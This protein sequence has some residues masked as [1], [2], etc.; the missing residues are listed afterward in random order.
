MFNEVPFLDRFE[1]AAL[2]GFRAVEFMFPWAYEP[3]RIA[4][5]ATRHGLEIVLFNVGGGDWDGGERGIGSVPGREDELRADVDR[6]RHYANI[7]GCRKLHLMAGK[8]NG[9]RAA[10][11]AVLVEN[12][13][14][15]ATVVAPDGIDILIEPINT[16]VDIPGYFYATTADA[17][18]VI[19]EVGLPNVKLQYDIY[20]MQIMEGDVARTIERLLPRIGHIQLADNPGRHE[21]GTGE[22]AYPWLLGHI[23]AL[24]YRGAI[25]CEYRPA[26]ETETG[27]AWTAPYLGERTVLV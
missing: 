6:A 26:A 23:D 14:H 22:I 4:E 11:H 25:G 2:A 16:K 18:A 5:A 8:V 21:P 19:D 7:L 12:I 13:R 15:A 17:L 20:H 9:D 27:L 10:A 3:E 24:G 1:K